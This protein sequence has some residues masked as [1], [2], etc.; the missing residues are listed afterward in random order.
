MILGI[1]IDLCDTRRIAQ[2]LDRFGQ[3]FLDRCFTAAEQAACV[4]RADTAQRLAR[5][6][7]AKEAA[8]KALGT[9][10]GEF[11]GL[12]ELEVISAANGKPDLRITGAAA[13]T[14]SAMTPDG[15]TGM[16]HISLTDEGDLAQAF[17]VLEAR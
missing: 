13:E 8:S 4:D 12:K 14:L 3:R 11:A 2:S 9:G 1:G 15:M 10:I 7:A 5:R 16:A 17:V 6:Y